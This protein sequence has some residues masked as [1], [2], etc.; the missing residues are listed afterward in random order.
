ML[1]IYKIYLRA[2]SEAIVCARR[3]CAGHGQRTPTASTRSTTT[4][5]R[6]HEPEGGRRTKDRLRRGEGRTGRG[7]ECGN[8]GVRVAVLVPSSTSEHR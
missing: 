8:D 1:Y 7:Q 3:A 2:P 5:L 4:T 6:R